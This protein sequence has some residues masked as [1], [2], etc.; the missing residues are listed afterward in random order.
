MGKYCAVRNSNE[1]LLW[2]SEEKSLPAPILLPSSPLSLLP[3]SLPHCLVSVNATGSVTMLTVEGECVQVIGEVVIGGRR[4][5]RRQLQV[6][7][8]VI[9]DVRG[10]ECVVVMCGSGEVYVCAL[11][12]KGLT[13]AVTI[14]LGAKAINKSM[15]AVCGE[16]VIVAGSDG[17]VCVHD[18]SS[19][20]SP[21]HPLTSTPLTP[22]S[23]ITAVSSDHFA[24]VE[25]GCVVSLRDTTYGTCQASM[26]TGLLS[27]TMVWCVCGHLVLFGGEGVRVCRVTGVEG[28]S[29]ATV[30]GQRNT[31]PQEA[32]LVTPGWVDPT[33][34]CSDWRSAVAAGDSEEVSRVHQLC[35]PRKTPTLDAVMSIFP[36]PLTL[37]SL[38]YSLLVRRLL[39]ERQFWAHSALVE[40]VKHGAVTGSVTGELV[41]RALD[42]SDWAL[43]LLTL[44]CSQDVPEGML[45]C[46]LQRTLKLPEEIESYGESLKRD[47]IMWATLALPYSD[48]L[49]QQPLS[50]MPLSAV[51][52]LL[53]FLTPS[54]SVSSLCHQPPIP[55]THLLDWLS[56]T[57][58]THWTALALS[59]HA[60]AIVKNYKHTTYHQMLFCEN[61]S[62]VQNLLEAARNPR[63]R[64]PVERWKMRTERLDLAI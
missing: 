45:V 47:D 43:I 13:L 1:L 4:T 23:F 41:A 11:D 44:H 31:P 24:V 38:S 55:Y 2:V 10:K 39:S 26:E 17:V 59:P 57:L 58:D 64:Q 37:H 50:Q 32:L 3:P 25:P 46:L 27:V 33:E 40:L 62:A 6:L 16:S 21:L 63:Q 20:T 53:Q 54:V 22:H 34:A 30:L 14:E 36:S 15:V 48:S 5:R 12:D 19:T 61:M 28:V 51:L 7:K 52:S 9:C 60:R 56:I 29:L 42:H 35:D 18:L 49:L 8:S